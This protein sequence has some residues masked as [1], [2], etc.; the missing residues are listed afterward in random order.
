M[1]CLRADSDDH[2]VRPARVEWATELEREG[3][4]ELSSFERVNRWV[5]MPRLQP[6]NAGLV[7][8]WNE[9]GAS[10]Q[11]WRSMF[12]MRSMIRLT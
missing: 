4:V 12:F 11:F 8:L 3:L 5:L 10:I 1:G 6:D 2:R 7:T 9:N